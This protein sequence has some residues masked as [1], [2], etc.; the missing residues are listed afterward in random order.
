ALLG[1]IVARLAGTDIDELPGPR[2]SIQAGCALGAVLL[3]LL[4]AGQR[5]GDHTAVPNPPDA[6]ERH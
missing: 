2:L 5:D 1:S 4:T 3:A 6:R